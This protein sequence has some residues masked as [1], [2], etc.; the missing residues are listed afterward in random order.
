MYT[1]EDIFKKEGK[2][3][4]EPHEDMPKLV[5]LLRKYK[6][7]KILDVGC[8]TGRHLIY[9]AKK[10]FDIYGLDN[11][12]TALNMARSWLKKLKLKAHLKNLNFYQSLPYKNNFFDAVISH[13]A[14]HHGT[15]QQV[16]KAIS[17]INRILKKNGIIFITVPQ[18]HHKSSIQPTASF[19]GKKIEERVIV[20][21]E[22]PEKGIPHFYFNKKLL[23]EFFCDFEIQELYTKNRDYRLIG[24]K[25]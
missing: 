6:A 25:K 9:L 20:P 13:N 8:G 3:F 11:S 7:K 4:E 14:I 15:T 16:K 22:G 2:V 23:K 10:N 21:Q 18:R 5:K 12:Q 24:L 1:W 19:K 17:E